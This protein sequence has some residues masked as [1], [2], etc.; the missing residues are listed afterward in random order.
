[1]RYYSYWALNKFPRR[2]EKEPGNRETVLPHLMEETPVNYQKEHKAKDLSTG[3][4]SRTVTLL[5]LHRRAG[6]EVKRLFKMH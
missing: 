4:A 6:D 5:R 1:M 3:D 2:E